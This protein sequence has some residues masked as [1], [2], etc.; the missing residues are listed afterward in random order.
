MP[1]IQKF[2]FVLVWGEVW[3]GGIGDFA[4]AFGINWGEGRGLRLG[5]TRKS[6]IL[7]RFK[8]FDKVII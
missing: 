4:L 3:L 1:N 6:T 8:F 5:G 7:D 2:I